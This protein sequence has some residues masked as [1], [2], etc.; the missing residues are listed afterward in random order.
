MRILVV[1]DIHTDYIPMRHIC[2][3]EHPD[4]VLDCGDHAEMANWAGLIPHYF[5]EG[6][7]EPKEVVIDSK[8]LRHPNKISLGVIYK[9]FKDNDKLKFAGIGGNYSSKPGNLTVKESDITAL[10]K[11]PAGSLDVLLLHES[12]YNVLVSIDNDSDSSHSIKTRLPFK[13]IDEI[14]RINP[15]YVFSGHIGFKKDFKEKK[16]R[17]ITL[18]EVAKGYGILEINVGEFLYKGKTL[19]W[20]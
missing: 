7:H 18:P 2:N 6:N 10:R 16:V 1:S 9:F 5:V 4:L 8:D 20:R 12:P 17:H 19:R 13:M 14:E 15:K 3:T 11:I